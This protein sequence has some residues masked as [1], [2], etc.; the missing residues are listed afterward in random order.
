M[1]SLKEVVHRWK[2]GCIWSNFSMYIYAFSLFRCNKS[3]LCF[4]GV[5]LGRDQKSLWDINTIQYSWCTDPLSVILS[6]DIQEEVHTLFLH[7]HRY[8]GTDIAS[9]VYCNLA[10]TNPLSLVSKGST[11][12]HCKISKNWISP[13]IH[14][15]TVAKD[16]NHCLW[17]YVMPFMHFIF[18][19]FL[20]IIHIKWWDKKT[21]G[22]I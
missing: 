9:G 15:W 16:K 4:V 1:L 7:N 6:Y 12:P 20:K 21:R 2:Y 18:Y 8:S 13:C 19:Q 14:S 17:N 11:S 22:N 3:A 5:K 10:Q